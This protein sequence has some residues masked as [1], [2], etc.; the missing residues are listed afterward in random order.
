MTSYPSSSLSNLAPDGSMINEE[1]RMNHGDFGGRQSTT[2]AHGT[3][4]EYPPMLQR[5]V[6]GAQFIKVH[7]VARW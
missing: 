7:H 1:I 2:C 3:P 4:E 5:E 6:D